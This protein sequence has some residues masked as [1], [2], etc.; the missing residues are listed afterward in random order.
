ML[1]NY[2]F[3]LFCILYVEGD[4]IEIEIE[5]ERVDLCPNPTL[6]RSDIHDRIKGLN[7]MII[8]YVPEDKGSFLDSRI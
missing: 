4:V 3:L 5:T 2:F 6:Y 7:D 1:N 8:C